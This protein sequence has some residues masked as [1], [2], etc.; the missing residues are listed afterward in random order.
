MHKI[1]RKQLVERMDSD[2][3]KF[4]SALIP[5]VN[6]ILGVRMPE[7]RKLAKEIAK[8]DWRLYL[9]TAND[10]YFEE[11]M[12]QGLVI[13]YVKADLEELLMYVAK[14]VQKIDNWS[15]CDSF[16]SGLK[17]TKH[18]KERVW[19]FLQPY[20]DSEKE[21]ELRFGIVMLLIY[22]SEPDYIDRVLGLLDRVEHEGYYVKMAVAWALSICFVKLPDK[23]MDYLAEEN[24]LDLFTYNK[25]LQKI[26]ESTRVE[27]DMKK[28]IRSMKRR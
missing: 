25:A 9:Q 14:F 23:T 17:V 11:V 28:V 22:Y 8:D 27:Q 5:N 12:L 16:C 21:Y 1:I 4:S 19:S 26:T 15:V 6:H 13:G 10:E 20:M 7:L 2:Y 3:Q 24:S 18:N